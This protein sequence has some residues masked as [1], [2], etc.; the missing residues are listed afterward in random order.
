[1]PSLKTD[2][3]A[4]S[5]EQNAA[6]SGSIHAFLEYTKSTCM[7]IVIAFLVIILFVVGP[8]KPQGYAS[9]LFIRIAVALVLAYGI[10][11]NCQAME[12]MYNIKGVFTLN[13]MAD[14]RMNFIMSAVFTVL[15]LAL[16]ILLIYKHFNSK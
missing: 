14:I 2:Q 15:I 12:K 13:S 4:P 3:I 11:M 1:M 8:F 7:S 16:A 9:L 10:Y 5:D 6:T